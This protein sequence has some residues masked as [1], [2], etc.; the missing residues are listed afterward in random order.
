MNYLTMTKKQT[1]YFFIGAYILT[2]IIGILIFLLLE[3][4]TS[5]DPLMTTF[6]ANLGMTV[7][8]FAFSL[9]TKN[10][11]MYDPYWSVIPPFILVGWLIYLDAQIGIATIFIL[12]GIFLWAIRLTYNWWKNWTGFKEQDW[13]YDLIKERTK[14]YYLLSNFGA[15]H[16]IPTL[17]VYIQMINVYEVIIGSAKINVWLFIGFALMIF[18][19]VIQF[20]ADKQM[21]EFRQNRK[22]KSACIDQGIWRYSRH[23]NYLGELSLWVGVYLIY[24]SVYQS[25]DLNIIYPISMI[26]LFLFVSIP[27]MEKKLEVRPCY[28]AYKKQV[29]MLFPYRKGNKS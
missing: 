8:I 26:M 23:P 7:V 11:S 1:G 5:L 13:R 6:I 29:P 19:S 20:I 10:S 18:A 12:I 9:I 16:L 27:M 24:I 17:V 28:E 21:F 2:F 4:I 3:N 25:L 14:G 15:I 22:D